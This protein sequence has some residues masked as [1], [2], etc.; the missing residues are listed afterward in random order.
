MNSG[1]EACR[2]LPGLLYERRRQE[3][4]PQQQL[5]GLS[6]QAKAA[7]KQERTWTSQQLHQLAKEIAQ[8]K[9]FDHRTF[10]KSLSEESKAICEQ[11]NERN[12]KHRKSFNEQEWEE[13]RQKFDELGTPSVLPEAALPQAIDTDTLPEHSSDGTHVSEIPALLPAERET[14]WPQLSLVRSGETQ[15]ILES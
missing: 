12:N 11:L 7:S 2:L 1:F 3:T 6:D 8:I 9:P 10:Q 4:A 15:A 13:I 5:A 14:P